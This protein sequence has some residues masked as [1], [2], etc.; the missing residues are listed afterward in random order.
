MAL[1]VSLYLVFYLFLAQTLEPWEHW[2]VFAL[3]SSLI[4]AF[5]VPFVARLQLRYAATRPAFTEQ[6][7]DRL[8]RRYFIIWGVSGGLLLIAGWHSLIL[9]QL[10]LQGLILIDELA[11]L[12]PLLCSLY[13]LL[14]FFKGTR[15]SAFAAD[16]RAFNQSN[17]LRIQLVGMVLPAMVLFGVHDMIESQPLNAWQSIG[18]LT[19]V[20]LVIILCH[21]VLFTARLN[22]ESFSDEG[23]G[24]RLQVM[25]NEHGIRIP[26][27]WRWNTDLRIV[28]A[29]I[30][31]A[32]PWGRKL[33][34]TDGLIDRADDRQLESIIRHEVAHIRLGH[35]YWRLAIVVMPLVALL[36]GL[37]FDAVV[38]GASNGWV[39]LASR[40]VVLILCGLYLCYIVIF[41]GWQARLMEFEADLFAADLIGHHHHSNRHR[42]Q[43]LIEMLRIF[44]AEYPGMFSV[45]GWLHP[46]LI[47]RITFLQRANIH[48]GLVQSLRRKLIFG[49]FCLVAVGVGSLTSYFMIAH[50]G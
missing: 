4:C 15:S 17:W 18:L 49:K 28:N 27:M 39:V 37:A 3:V 40:E 32:F 42:Q 46:S 45:G 7:I 1:I 25:C 29:M 9:G 8:E 48:P 5:G 19:T 30:V 21:P 35:V 24:K 31:G 20:M 22:L 26:Q 2:T 34:V 16:K 38:H 44:A 11:V 23:L 13:W 36:C 14:T 10:Q 12:L 43:R 47:E 6:S 41:L 50:F 33:I